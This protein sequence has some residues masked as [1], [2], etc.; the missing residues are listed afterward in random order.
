MVVSGPSGVGKDTVLARV[1]ELDP[2]LSYSVS[3]TT[4]QPRPGER[5]GVDYSFV[6][7]AAFDGLIQAGRMLEWASVHNHRSGTG[8]DRVEKLLEQG[9]DMVL[10]VDVQGGAAVR[11][12]VDGA[13]L[14]FLAPPSLE[15]LAARLAK[16]ATESAAELERRAGDAQIEMGYADQYDAVVVNDD[17]ERAAHEVLKLIEERRRQ[18]RA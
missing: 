3:Y 4:R 14:V 8:R 17:I 7:D 15:E 9:R 18:N 11:G 5:D 1:F 6:S 10:N 12:L 16:R 2:Q 13:L